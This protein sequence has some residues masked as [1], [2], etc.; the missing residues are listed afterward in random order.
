M[1]QTVLI[2][3]EE[4]V[5]AV[6]GKEGRTPQ[7]KALDKVKLTGFGEAAERWK[8]G[9]RELS[10]KM[11]LRQVRLVLPSSLTSSK[12]IR[13]PW[14]KG[15][16]LSAMARREMQEAFRSEIMDYAVIESDKKTGVVLSC[17][18]VEEHV[19]VQ[20]LEICQ[21]LGIEV[22]SVTAPMEGLL[23]ILPRL[24]SY[25]EKTA[26]YLFFEEGAVTSVLSE[27][28]QYKYS[29]RSRL[30][31]EPGTLDFGTEI[32][33]NVSGILQF[34]AASKSEYPI[35]DVYYA[36]CAPDVFDVS[37]E[38]LANMHLEVAEMGTAEGVGFPKDRKGNGW[39][40]CIAA[41]LNGVKGF[42]DIDL[43]SVYQKSA[44]KKEEHTGKW[45]HAL[46]FLIAFGVC[47]LAY[48]GVQAANLS[49]RH[50]IEKDR[51]WMRSEKVQKVYGEAQAAERER[52]RLQKALAETKKLNENRATYPKL[53]RAV[54]TLI[55]AVGGA[56]IT[57]NISGYDSVT[58]TMTFEAKS[59]AAIDI[60]SYIGRLTDTGLFHTV[61]YTG[62]VFENDAYTLS[63]LCTLK[64]N[65]GEVSE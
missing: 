7:I 13:L 33:R 56:G 28:G 10:E 27:N 36:G 48:G 3:R 31:S 58:G 21:E 49:V 6:S 19:L 9:I 55:E 65:G 18:S 30:F 24:G 25:R 43:L 54:I 60:P 22:K 40:P 51:Q 35:T 39:V 15:R 29:S 57:S 26:V 37:R 50:A 5:Y 42:H 44:E 61:E 63:L 32:V 64:G 52:D 14:A 47:A 46:P 20:L 38:G 59:Q 34:Q 53:D 1:S 2:I 4:T 8:A 23:R 41:M 45:K 11:E 17:T 12:V 16:D 62:Y